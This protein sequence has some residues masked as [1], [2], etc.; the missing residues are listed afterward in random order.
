M[1]QQE[2]EV[3][4][5]PP[6]EEWQWDIRADG[7]RIPASSRSNTQTTEK[8]PSDAGRKDSKAGHIDRSP[9]ERSLFPGVR[10]ISVSSWSA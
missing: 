10:R 7:E 3:T 8:C 9:M 6:S 5:L 4:P 2:F 1:S